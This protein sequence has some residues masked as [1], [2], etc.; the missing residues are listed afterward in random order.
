V[1]TARLATVSSV[2]PLS[3]LDESWRAAQRVCMAELTVQ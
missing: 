2:E 1:L 3:T